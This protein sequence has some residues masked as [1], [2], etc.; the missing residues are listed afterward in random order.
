VKTHP[1]ESCSSLRLDL[2]TE[3]SVSSSRRAGGREA[4][5]FSNCVLDFPQPLFITRSHQSF[6]PCAVALWW[7]VLERSLESEGEKVVEVG[8]GRRGRGGE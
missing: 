3:G 4:D 6:E 1:V 7:C 8:D 5:L 2:S